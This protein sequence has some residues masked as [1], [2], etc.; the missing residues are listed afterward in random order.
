MNS[1]NYGT[2]I[3]ILLEDDTELTVTKVYFHEGFPRTNS[4]PEEPATVEVLTVENEDGI[5]V[6]FEEM[7]TIEHCDEIEEK[8]YSERKQNRL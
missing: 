4:E 6:E 3:T 5:E 7:I 1:G 8:F 2:N